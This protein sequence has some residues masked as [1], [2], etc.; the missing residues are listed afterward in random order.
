MADLST[1]WLRWAPYGE[2]EAVRE[3]WQC[4]AAANAA[5]AAAAAQAWVIVPPPPPKEKE[6]AA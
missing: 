2:I 3:F 1:A 5:A 6:T 4:Q